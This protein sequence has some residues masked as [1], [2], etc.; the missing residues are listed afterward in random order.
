MAG[1]TWHVSPLARQRMTSRVIARCNHDN[2]YDCKCKP[3]AFLCAQILKMGDL[4]SLVEVD[5]LHQQ[6]N[7][8]STCEYVDAVQ[9]YCIM[10]PVFAGRD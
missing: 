3:L 1:M 8:I 2:A 7:I 9:G 4:K 5:D 6:V 10:S